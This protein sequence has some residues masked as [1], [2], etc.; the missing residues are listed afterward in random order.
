[1]SVNTAK[2]DLNLLYLAIYVVIVKND[3]I[4][5]APTASNRLLRSIQP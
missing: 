3:Y 1:M 4:L 2:K 5:P